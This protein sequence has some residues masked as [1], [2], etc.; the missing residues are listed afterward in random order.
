ML[1]GVAPATNCRKYDLSDG[2]TSDWNL[3]D[4]KS[5]EPVDIVMKLKMLI[6]L[7]FRILQV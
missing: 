4:E 3:Y 7:R 6:N 1:N 2:R 5:N